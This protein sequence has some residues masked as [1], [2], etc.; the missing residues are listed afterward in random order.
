MKLAALA[1]PADPAPLT[2][3][4]DA[5]AMKQQKA[6]AARPRAVATVELGDALGGGGQQVL[7]AVHVFGRA[8]QPVGKKRE[9]KV[10]FGACEV[11]DLQPLNLF[12]DR[13]A[14][15]EHGRHR[16]H[17]AE[18]GRNAVAKLQSRQQRRAEVLRHAAVHQRDRRVD[19]GY[20]SQIRIAG[21]AIRH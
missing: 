8:V 5:A 16:D 20:R 9:M 15:R 2:C 7:V 1:L 17:R 19:G 10:A 4:P 14:G 13:R 18:V 11:V 21:L 3:I 6:I 12:L